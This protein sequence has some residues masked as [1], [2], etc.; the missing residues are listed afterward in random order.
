[1]TKKS[2]LLIGAMAMFT[3]PIA[4][5]RSYDIALSD[6][7]MVGTTQLAAGQYSVKVEGSNAVFTNE[8]NYKSVTAPVKIE[9]VAKKFFFNDA[10]T[11]KKG[12]VL[13]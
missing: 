7:T 9:N 5:A 4:S 3:L 13:I 6:P 12:G 11:T 10:A 2:L 1:M 8:D